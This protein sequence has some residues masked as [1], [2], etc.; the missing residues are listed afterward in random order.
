[1]LVEQILLEPLLL[2]FLVAILVALTGVGGGAVMTPALVLL[3]DVPL[4][5]AI[6]TDLLY[7]V[8]TKAVAV[9]K[10]AGH[11]Q[12]RWDLVRGLTLGSLPAVVIVLGLMALFGEVDGGVVYQPAVALALIFTAIVLIGGQGLRDRL[13]VFSRVPAHILLPVTGALLGGLV[14]LSSIGAGAIGVTAILLVA[15]SIAGRKLVATDLA[16]A[17]PL[18]VFAGIGHA[19]MGNVDYQLLLYLVIGAVPGALLGCQL[20]GRVPKDVLLKGV[21]FMLLT[22]S[23]SMI[24]V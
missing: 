7:I 13:Q 24:I 14:A 11:G 18:A 15:P 12:V 21:G 5:I 23:I 16:Q 8:V 10:H 19:V 6:G 1:M 2:G 9:S 17:F 4:G 22:I 20:C 3:L